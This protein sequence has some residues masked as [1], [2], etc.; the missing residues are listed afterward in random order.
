VTRPNVHLS[1][2]N[3]PA[4]VSLVRETLSGVAE[5]VN[6]GRE[7]LDDIKTAVSEACNNVVLHAYDGG[8]G[9]L[10]V[11]IFISGDSFDVVVCDVGVGMRPPTVNED[12]AQGVGLAVIAALSDRVEF[13]GENGT[14]LRMSFP[15]AG[16]SAE[17]AAPAATAGAGPVSLLPG[18]VVVSVSPED[19]APAILSRLAGAVSA[20]ARFSID[21]LSDAQLVT[22]ALAGASDPV[23]LGLSASERRLDL[24]LGPLEPGCG[25][26]VLR[27]SSVDGLLTKL[28]DEVTTEPSGTHEMLHLALNDKR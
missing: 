7:Q 11:E 25:E 2:H 5:A 27:E 20:R 23:T 8:P 19:F 21:R 10:T 17:L 16:G 6:M 13:S 3:E 18:E 24:R 12:R 1:L 14:S 15:A 9:P 26:R 28:V 4:N 22:D